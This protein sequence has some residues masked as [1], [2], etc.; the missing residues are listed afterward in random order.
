MVET[1]IPNTLTI[2]EVETLIGVGLGDSGLNSSKLSN[3]KNDLCQNSQISVMTTAI[4]NYQYH[5]LTP[6]PLTNWVYGIQTVPDDSSRGRTVKDD[7]GVYR[8]FYKPCYQNGTDYIYG[9]VIGTATDDGQTPRVNEPGGNPGVFGHGL[10]TYKRQLDFD[11]S[12][13]LNAINVSKMSFLTM[14]KAA[15][16]QPYTLFPEEVGLTIGGLPTSTNKKMTPPSAS[17]GGDVLQDD[18]DAPSY[19]LDTVAAH[20]VLNGTYINGLATAFDAKSKSALLGGMYDLAIKT[21]SAGD[22]PTVFSPTGKFNGEFETSPLEKAPIVYA[23]KVTR[24]TKASVQTF[25]QP[26]PVAFSDGPYYIPRLVINNTPL[27]ATPNINLNTGYVGKH[28]FI[29]SDVGSDILQLN[30][31][32]LAISLNDTTG[33]T[34]AHFNMNVDAAVRVYSVLGEVPKI[35]TPNTVPGEVVAFDIT[36]LANDRKFDLYRIPVTPPGVHLMGYGF[37]GIVLVAKRILQNKGVTV[38]DDLYNCYNAT[39]KFPMLIAGMV[40]KIGT[41]NSIDN[42]NQDAGVADD[43]KA[44]DATLAGEQTALDPPQKLGYKIGTTTTDGTTMGRRCYQSAIV[45]RLVDTGVIVN[46]NSNIELELGSFQISVNDLNVGDTVKVAGVSFGNPPQS[47][48]G[49]HEILSVNVAANTIEVTNPDSVVNPSLATSTSSVTYNTTTGKPNASAQSFDQYLVNIAMAFNAAGIFQTQSDWENNFWVQAVQNSITTNWAGENGTGGA[50]ARPAAWAGFTA[51][52]SLTPAM[53]GEFYKAIIDVHAFDMPSYMNWLAQQRGGSQVQHFP[54]DFTQETYNELITISTNNDGTHLCGISCDDLEY[55]YTNNKPGICPFKSSV[56]G[57]TGGAGKNAERW[58]VIPCGRPT[59][60]MA[61]GGGGMASSIQ[62]GTILST[63]GSRGINR[64]ADTT[65]YDTGLPPPNREETYNTTQSTY[66][67]VNKVKEAKEGKTGAAS[68]IK[69]KYSGA[70]PN[71]LVFGGNNL[72]GYP[73]GLDYF[74]AEQ[75]ERII[76]YGKPK[77][78]WAYVLYD[79]SANADV[80]KSSGIFL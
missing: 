27:L 13:A 42:G 44:Y 37:I 71:T 32:N 21:D 12:D 69:L 40:N 35:T 28:G 16:T 9:R 14:G 65:L 18:L 3:N 49:D 5:Q 6:D 22:E 17:M 73:Y 63:D 26:G 46:G 67:I 76:E 36:N 64:S 74:S 10:Y 68:P 15:T 25:N 57:F 62:N 60:G 24:I 59:T 34:T 80:P 50:G 78:R 53:M 30:E 8:D 38:T 48:D 52:T 77:Y 47:I 39:N 43:R 29:D 75:T 19:R 1:D 41:P 2:D 72:R 66:S 58:S 20:G 31:N 23:N 79:V 70:P 11:N 7:Q 54:T 33:S 4:W 45:Q 56:G 55:G 61:W 51:P